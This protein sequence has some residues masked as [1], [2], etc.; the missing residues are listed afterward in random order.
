MSSKGFY[1]QLISQRRPLLTLALAVITLAAGYFYLTLPVVT[2]TEAIVPKDEKRLFYEEFRQV[3]GADDALGIA[4]KSERL[5]S[6]EILTFIRELTEALEEI[7]EVED[8]LSLTNVEDIRGGQGVFIVEPLVGEEIPTSAQRLAWIKK[9]ALSNPLIR[10]NLISTDGQAT[11]ILVRPA[12][13]GEDEDLEARLLEAVEKK[14][15]EIRARFPGAPRLHLAGWPVIDVKMAAYMNSDLAVFIPLTY[16]LMALLLYLFLR[17]IRAVVGILAVMTLSLV[18]TMAA[19]NLVG[20]AMSPMTAILSPLIMALSLADGVHLTSRFYL[21]LD[22]PGAKPQKNFSDLVV[23]AVGESW[24]PCLLTSLTTAAGFLSLVT[25]RIPAIRHFGLAAAA[26]MIIEF[27]LTFTLL[28]M[29]LPWLGQEA[30]RGNSPVRESAL[31]S[32]SQKLTRLAVTRGRWIIL[33]TLAVVLISLWGASKIR[34]ETNLL[35]FFREKS[36]IRVAARFVDQN[37]GGSETLEISIRAKETEAFLDPENLRFLEDIAAF[38]KNRPA[39]SKVVGAHD[40][41]K[42]M[43][44][45]FHEDDPRFYRLPHS[46]ELLAQYLLLYSGTELSHFLDEDRSWARLSARTVVHNS[47][48]LEEEIE[49]LT[50]FIHRLEPEKR[51]LEVRITGKTYLNTQVIKDIVS[52]QVQSLT[53]AGGIVFA[54]IFL[55]LRSLTLGLVAM[56]PNFLPLVT[57][58]GLMGWA[59]IPLNTST[60]TISAVAIGIVVDDTI[61][62]LNQYQML[63]RAGLSVDQAI[64]GTL[65]VKGGAVTVTSVILIVAF[66]ILV[67]SRFV[68]TVQFGFLSAMIML[69]ALLGDIF[70][71][72]AILA[73]KKKGG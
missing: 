6:P 67:T 59:G 38:L 60:A 35:E 69:V 31:V 66:G 15:K 3:F 1:Y 72:P 44:Q 5:F 4:F 18:W 52:S 17:R 64:L 34:T 54:F 39:F 20:G 63:R 8:V 19:L 32:A 43:N 57:N 2:S 58:F 23:K 16:V 27:I 41:L 47:S 71:L 7:P 13:H 56:A 73:Q 25:S 21:E 24:R 26:G 42:Q 9:R 22:R 48:A 61:H 46:R 40:F 55:A 45:A 51:G 28:A 12:F 68:P 33:F 29:L 14:I 11:M 70:L 65:I 30:A 37:L 10:G 49:D 36:P 62:F 53:M 50:E